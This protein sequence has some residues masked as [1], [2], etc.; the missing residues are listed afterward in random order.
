MKVF[1]V[2]AL[3]LTLLGCAAPKKG[4]D[5]YSSDEIRSIK[6]DIITNNQD[7]EISYSNYIDDSIPRQKKFSKVI[8]KGNFEGELEVPKGQT[9]FIYAKNPDKVGFYTTGEI[10]VN[11]TDKFV[12]G[13]IEINKVLPELIKIIK[14]LNEQQKRELLKII[15]LFE[16]TLNSPRYLV[17]SMQSRAN[18]DLEIFYRDT[19][20]KYTQLYSYF[21]SMD[22]IIDFAMLP[23]ASGRAS[24][25][26]VSKAKRML[27]TLRIATEL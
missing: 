20:T 11:P 6:V 13:K 16:E 1:L 2:I 3:A 4:L 21:K 19:G 26:D 22:L 15:G 10:K 7:L 18:S 14:P 25:E 12:S 8:S 27:S 17:K 24:Y 5:L 23:N 9:L